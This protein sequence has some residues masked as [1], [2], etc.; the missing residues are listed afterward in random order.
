MVQAYPFLPPI[1]PPH[2]HPGTRTRTCPQPGPVILSTSTKAGVAM[3][4]TLEL[5][6]G[7]KQ[8]A[9][10]SWAAGVLLRTWSERSMETALMITCSSNSRH[11]YL[12]AAAAA[13]SSNSRHGHLQAATVAAVMIT[14]RQKQAGL[15]HLRPAAAGSSSTVSHFVMMML[16]W[17]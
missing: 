15:Q 12:Q 2:T 8:A 1:H 14:F 7:R 9:A 5:N 10:S 13:G 3:S 16:L 11:G 6:S 17:Q 4:A